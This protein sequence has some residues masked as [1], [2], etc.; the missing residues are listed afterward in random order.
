MWMVSHNKLFISAS[1]CNS[2]T[3]GDIIVCKFW[4]DSCMN[5]SVIPSV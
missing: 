2:E 4:C 3:G 5:L 1:L